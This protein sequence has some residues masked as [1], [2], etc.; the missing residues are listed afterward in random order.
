MDTIQAQIDSV[1]EIH[2]L[3]LAIVAERRRHDQA[4]EDLGRQYNT[5]VARAAH[6]QRNQGCTPPVKA[7]P[8][9]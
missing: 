7:G 9:D 2:E 5:A 8:V 1:N 6:A 4:I 3:Q